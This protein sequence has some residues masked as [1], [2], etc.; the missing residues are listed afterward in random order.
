[1]IIDAFTFFN[2]YDM[3]EFRLKLLWEH[4]DKFVIV[5]ADHTFSGKT[6]PWNFYENRERYAWA[7]DKI[8]Y[9]QFRAPNP[10]D[11]ENPPTTTDPKHPCWQGEYDQRNAIEQA[12]IGFSDDATLLISDCDEIPSHKIFNNLPNLLRWQ[13]VALRQ[14]FFYYNLSCLRNEQWNGTIITSLGM[15][16]VEGIQNL[17]AQRNVLQM[18]GEGGWHLSY[19]SDTKGIQE[20]LNSFSHVEYNTPQYNNDEHIEE[21]VRERKD[22]FVRGMKA[23]AIERD[24]FPKYFLKQSDNFKW[25][26]EK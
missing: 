9:H 14:S 15:A 18:V 22:L 3:L 10:W 12:C 19:F 26:G 11:G 5:E 13:P 25:W 17:R 8:V 16:R 4:V 2:E 20:K 24:F 23:N 21:C 6:K 7:M 1:M